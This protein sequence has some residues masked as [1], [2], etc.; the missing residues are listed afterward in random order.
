MSNKS[1]ATIAID[2]VRNSFH[3]V[4]SI[5]VARSR[6][7]SESR[8]PIEPRLARLRGS[9]E[10]V[11]HCENSPRRD[12]PSALQ[13]ARERPGRQRIGIIRCLRTELGAWRSW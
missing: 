5:G 6:R 3:V 8:G 12:G 2:I 7:R 10:A 1:I 4:G 11:Q 9:C 13:Q